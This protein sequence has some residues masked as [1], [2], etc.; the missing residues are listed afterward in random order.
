MPKRRRKISTTIAPESY[1]FLRGFIQS[2]KARNLADA[3]DAILEE[4]G[5]AENRARLEKATAE[6]FERLSPEALAEEN[7]LGEAISR[8][9]GE[10]IFSDE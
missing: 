2:G 4:K 3:L 5:L 8:A 10:V 7:E 1:D 9:A 6:Y